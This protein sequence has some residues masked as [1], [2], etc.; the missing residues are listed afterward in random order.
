MC[1]SENSRM[2]VRFQAAA[3][4]SI[5]QRQISHAALWLLICLGGGSITVLTLYLAAGTPLFNRGPL[6]Q[7]NAQVR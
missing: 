2:P 4:S 6:P 1:V 5:L 7:C 3:P